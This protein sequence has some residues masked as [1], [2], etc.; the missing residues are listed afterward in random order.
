MLDGHE[1]H[2]LL[3][4]VKGELAPQVSLIHKF[5]ELW[6]RKLLISSTILH[7][8]EKS[9]ERRKKKLLSAENVRMDPYNIQWPLDCWAVG[10]GAGGRTG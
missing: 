4:E 3:G 6:E 2:T 10:V 7:H 8:H 5:T 1:L 9:T